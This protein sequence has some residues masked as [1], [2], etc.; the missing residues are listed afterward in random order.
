MDRRIDLHIHST[1]SDGNKTP[2]EILELAREKNLIAFSITDH[3]NIGA[4]SE[5]KKLRRKDD[6][7]IIIGVELSTG[8]GGE[9]LHILGYFMD[10]DSEIFLTRLKGFRKIR[11]SRGARMLKEL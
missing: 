1:F 4:Y 7:E 9:D 11:N 6:P 5:V 2:A 8:R 3:D 10:P